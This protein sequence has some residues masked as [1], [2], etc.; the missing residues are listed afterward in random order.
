MVSGGWPALVT[1]TWMVY[2]TVSIQKVASIFSA[3]ALGAAAWASPSRKAILL[4]PPPNS[5]FPGW[6]EMLI[7]TAEVTVC[8]WL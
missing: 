7:L 2:S 5:G 3:W 4:T 6:V 8:C 1:G